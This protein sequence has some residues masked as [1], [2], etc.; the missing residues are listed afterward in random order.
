MTHLRQLEEDIH[1]NR[2]L[3]KAFNEDGLDLSILEY[4]DKKNKDLLLQREQAWINEFNSTDPAYGYNKINSQSDQYFNKNNINYLTRPPFWYIMME[5]LS[6]LNK[7][8]RVAWNILK[9]CITSK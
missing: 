6:K 9:R 8:T 7:H 2:E 5:E 1:S 3:Q 4:I